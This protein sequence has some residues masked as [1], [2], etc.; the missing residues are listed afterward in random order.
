M[1]NTVGIKLANFVYNKMPVLMQLIFPV[2]KLLLP[3]TIKHKTIVQKENL[4]LLTG[5]KD[6]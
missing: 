1:R 3:Q 2:K 4:I 5:I 6:K